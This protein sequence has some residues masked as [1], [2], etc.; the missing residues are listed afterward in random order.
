M[1]LSPT[2]FNV[3]LLSVQDLIDGSYVQPNVDAKTLVPSIKLVQDMYLQPIL[4]TAFL[5]HLQTAVSTNTLTADETNLLIMYIK[6][7]MAQYTM[8]ENVFANSFKY[9]VKGLEQMQSD[10]SDPA[11][12][13]TIEAFSER[14]RSAGSQYAQR[15]I[16]YLTHSY[17]L[18]PTYNESMV[19]EGDMLPNRRNAYQGNFNL[20]PDE[21]DYFGYRGRGFR[22][23]RIFV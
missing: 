14:F 6:P 18:F 3:L 2:A 22:G 11:S 20:H 8:M 5:S 1:S 15:L 16:D 23:P 17:A 9:T 19:S 21:R 10:N 7:M 12:I 4:G 13:N